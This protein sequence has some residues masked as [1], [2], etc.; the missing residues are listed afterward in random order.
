MRE[1]ALEAYGGT[2]SLWRRARGWAINYATIVLE[3][4]DDPL[5]AESGARTLRNLIAGP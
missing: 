4:R 5:H 2:E 1:R 3:L